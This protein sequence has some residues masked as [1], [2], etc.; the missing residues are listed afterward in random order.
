MTC[1]WFRRPCRVAA[2]HDTIV[3]TVP[4]GPRGFL[5]FIFRMEIGSFPVLSAFVWAMF[6][7][8]FWFYLIFYNTAVSMQPLSPPIFEN[9]VP[10]FKTNKIF[11][12]VLSICVFLI[13]CSCFCRFVGTPSPPPGTDWSHLWSMLV[14]FLFD[15]G[16]RCRTTKEE[17]TK[18]RLP[19]AK[20]S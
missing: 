4:F 1:S 13:G 7:I 5:N 10:Q 6:H 12:L 19:S 3:I 2:F 9:I 20:H 8:T 15:V 17:T 18:R 16:R 11:M 14:S